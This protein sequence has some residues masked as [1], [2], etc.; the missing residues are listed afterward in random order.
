[1][2]SAR[3]QAR[4]KVAA[5]PTLLTDYDLHLLA[6]GTHYRSYDRLGAHLVQ[7]NGQRGT[8]F[9]VWAPNAER[10]SVVGDFNDWN[11]AA[12]PMTQR[13][14]AGMWTRFIPGVGAGALYKYAIASRYNGY[15]VDKADPYAFASEIRPQTASK[16]W[17]ISGYTW[18]DHDWMASRA[19]A[20]AL[21]AP[22]A[23][24]EVHL[25]S[26]MRVPEEGHRWL[27]YREIAPKL[28]DYV[29]QMGYTHVQFLPLCEHPFDGSWGYQT[30]GYFAP[31][32]RFGTPQDLMFL[33]DYLH[34][35]GIGVLIDWV[36]AHFPRDAHG[37]VYFDGTHLYEHAD[38]RQGEHREWGTAVF[39]YGRPEVSNFLLS[40][41]LFWPD[42][43]HIDGL[44]V[45][46]VA[47]MLYL[48]YARRE[49]D[50][51]PNKYG[52]REN[53]EAVAFVRRFNELVYAHYPGVITIAEESTSWGMVSRPTY[54]GGLGFG[55]KWDMGWMNDT[56]A[57]FRHDPVHRRY[58]HNQLTFRMLYAF[59]ENFMLPLSHDE[60]VHG[61]GSLLGKMPGDDW[62]K[63]ANLRLLFGYMY[64][65]PGKK[66]LFMGGDVGQRREWNHDESVE[67]YLLAHAPH[68]GLQQWVQDLNALYRGEP[69]LH[70]LDCEPGGFEW[71]D[72]NDA[73]C[74]V[75]SYLR[76]GK[77]D[78]EV[79]VIACNFTPVPRQNYGVGVPRG[80]SWKEVLNS[81]S[82][83]YGGSNVGNAGG[84]TATGTPLHGRPDSLRVILPPLGVVIFKPEK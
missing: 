7:L 59:T 41:A 24:Y 3:T 37:L 22:I 9:A 4:S 25:G 79:L 75:L 80:G 69:A 76:R 40:N 57:Y 16:V 42:K 52:G 48:D 28:A 15:H 11:P 5:D 56:L 26:W 20:N 83:L 44:R 54:L 51:I 8:H 74:G 36:P 62:R 60:V 17:D 32:S 19:R 39:N 18:A 84:L 47:S 71:I 1:M 27:S 35:R 73:D 66:L 82:A 6:E 10:V 13:P 49:G 33:I 45:D 77:A 34:Q 31:T 53:L 67:W 21:D 81:D 68:R 50:W 63:F 46:A 12:H 78:G 70:Q 55:I 2:T 29:L 65:Q 61:K 14:E 30:V 23:V 72:C 64:T 58:H 38:P 43:Y